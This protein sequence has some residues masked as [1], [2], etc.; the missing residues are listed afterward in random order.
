MDVRSE[1]GLRPARREPKVQITVVCEGKLTEPQYIQA[2]AT[3]H[4]TL[5]I[6]E[7]VAGVPMLVVLK[8]M[9]CKPK[10]RHNNIDSFAK[11]DQVWAVFDR[12]EHPQFDDAIDKAEAAGVRVCYSNPCFELWL[13]LHFKNWDAPAHR[14]EIQDALTQLMPAYDRKNKICDFTAMKDFV[15]QAEA[16]GEGLVRNREKERSPRGNPSTTF[17]KSTEQIRL[18]GHR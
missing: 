1:L 9:A 6:I 18:N 2:L 10:K 15:L 16:R 14:S 12:D 4:G 3:H 13:V 7:K 17:Y 5:V 11:N 8:A